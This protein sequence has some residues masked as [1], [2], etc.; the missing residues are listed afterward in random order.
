MAK[1][2]VTGG[3]GFIGSHLIEKLVA[4]G[5]E[6]VVVDNLLSGRRDN[7]P[8]NVRL[9]EAD[10]CDVLDLRDQIGEVD[11]IFHLAALISGHDSL[12]EADAYWQTNLTGVLRLIDFTAGSTRK[13]KLIFASSST[14]YGNQPPGHIT[15]AALPAPT[16]TYALTKLAAEHSLRMY[17]ELYGIEHVALR[18][19][20]VY[21]PRQNPDHPYANVTCKFARA[22]AQGLPIKLFGDGLQSR[23][24]VYISDVVDAFLAVRGPCKH[25]LYNVGTGHV[26]T[27][28]ELIDTIESLTST[29]FEIEQCPPWPN[30]IRTISADTTRI[31]DEFDLAT[32]TSIDVGLGATVEYF[33]QCR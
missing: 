13:P 31:R 25:H 32:P 30:D 8:A 18:L 29:S 17:G 14:V 12:G 19:F 26:T 3:A 9:I 20:N 7:L 2:L 16:T 6:V 28:R 5:D 23:D 1:V 33:A 15:E 4:G 24:F 10:V 22:G 21:G 27:I 11:Q